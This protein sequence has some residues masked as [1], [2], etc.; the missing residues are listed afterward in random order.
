MIFNP[1]EIFG[2]KMIPKIIHYCWFGSNPYPEKVEY[3]ISTWKRV[4]PDYEFILWNEENFDVDSSLFTKQAYENGKYAFVSDYVRIYALVEM[5]GIY[6]DT[7][8]EVIKS[9]KDILN[10]S[11]CLGADESG[12]LTAFMASEKK[13]KLFCD[14]LEIYNNL[15]F[16]NSKGKFDLT[17]NNIRIEK[18][19]IRYGYTIKN[20]YQELSNNIIVCPDD[21]FHA[22]NMTS[23]KMNVSNNTYCIHHH[24]LLWVPVKFKIIKFLRTK[25]LVPLFGEKK[26]RKMV[27]KIRRIKNPNSN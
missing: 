5:G 17:V 16:Y 14:M 12:H 2:G 8:I 18:E 10:S 1:C 24:T 23:G 21:Y 7:D 26:Y 11:V 19:L 6:L 9:F 13:H 27:N 4:L 20:Q 15:S 3:C 25:F 22:K